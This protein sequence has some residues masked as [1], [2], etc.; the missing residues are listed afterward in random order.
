MEIFQEFQDK[1]LDLL[2][3][4]W[5]IGPIAP[6]STSCKDFNATEIIHQLQ[7]WENWNY[8]EMQTRGMFAPILDYYVESKGT[9]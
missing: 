2:G 3:S 6:G 1:F 8:S 9:P 7:I 5:F 4:V